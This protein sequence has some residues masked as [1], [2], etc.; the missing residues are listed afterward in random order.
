MRSLER[1]N[2]LNAITED[3]L[4]T[5]SEERDEI[6]IDLQRSSDRTKENSQLLDTDLR[7]NLGIFR[8]VTTEIK[9]SNFGDDS[10]PRIED[11]EPLDDYGNEDYGNEDRET[12]ENEEDI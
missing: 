11:T 9:S 12:L 3:N 1:I 7:R 10:P 2:L 8:K 6:L 4:P 5:Y